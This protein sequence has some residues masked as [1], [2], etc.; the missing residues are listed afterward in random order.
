MTIRP[1]KDYLTDTILYLI[2]LIGVSFIFIFGLGTSL[3]ASV[4]LLSPI[5]LLFWLQRISSGRT[6]ILDEEGHTIC[7]LWMRKKYFWNDLRTKRII[8]Y[9]RLPLIYSKSDCPYKKGAIFAPFHV[10]K[11]KWIRPMVYSWLHPWK[12]VYVN[13]SI[14]DASLFG[15]KASYAG[16]HYEVDECDF[17]NMMKKWNIVLHEASDAPK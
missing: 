3:G 1:N 5:W 10:R 4:A 14:P 11:P 15:K 17:C 16:R 7:F 2:C 8:E 6:F 13:F 12:L 9:P